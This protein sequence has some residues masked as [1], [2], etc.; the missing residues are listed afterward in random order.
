[1][2]MFVLRQ[3]FFDLGI[4]F[5]D[6]FGVAREGRPTERTNATTEKWTDVGR[7][8]TGECE[9]VFKPF[10]KCDLTD[11]IAVIQCRYASV[12]EIYHRRNVDLHRG[13]CSFFD[14][15]RI[16]F[17]LVLPLRHRPTLR[18]ITIDRIM[19]RG[20]VRHDIRVHAALY[21]LRENISGI[22]EQAD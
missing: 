11:V 1:M 4:R 5:V 7:Y 22:A 18:Q 10:L 19:C 8:K 3:D 13:A 12:P 6:V 2:Q 17:A 20:L 16:A 21:Q 15:L 14:R 9:S